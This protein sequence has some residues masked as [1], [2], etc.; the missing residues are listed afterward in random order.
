MAFNN[1]PCGFGKVESGYRY[2][3][4]TLGGSLGWGL[5]CSMMGFIY[6][7]GGVKLI[8]LI[9]ALTLTL[10]Y[11][12]FY[13]A[14][15]KEYDIIRKYDDKSKT[16]SVNKIPKNLLVFLLAVGISYFGASWSFNVLSIKLYIEVERNEVIYGIIYGGLTSLIGSMVRPYAG[17]LSDR[18]GSLKLYKA[19]LASYSLL[20]FL[21]AISRG[22]VMAVLWLI[23]IYPLYDISVVTT[24][25]SFEPKHLKA[26][27]IGSLYTVM[28][29]SGSLIPIV[30]PL[31]D[32][33]GVQYSVLLAS[34]LQIAALLALVLKF[35]L[36]GILKT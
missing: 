14:Y 27:A 6:G 17:K 21:L 1:C 32:I 18:V 11:I 9:A 31:T 20:M 10:S 35:N 12:V 29:I 16:S 3:T 25:S 33:W 23:P 2:G 4:V 15:P 5:G 34:A 24:V 22:I 8:T 19:S 7:F 28:S 30:G 36:K 13:I 26:S